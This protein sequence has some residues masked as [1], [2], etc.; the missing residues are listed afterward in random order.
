MS[1]LALVFGLV[2]A[3]AAPPLQAGAAT[4]NITPELGTL[5]V[6]G[7]VRDPYQPGNITMVDNFD[8]NGIDANRLLL[9]TAVL[10]KRVGMD[11]SDQ[12]IFVNVVGGMSIDEPAADLAVACAI[13]S[14][15]RNRPVWADLVFVGEVGLSGELR[16]TGQLARRLHEA[17]KLGFTRALATILDSNIT[18]FLAHAILFFVGTGPVKGFAVTTC[19]GLGTTIFTAFTLTRLMVAAWYRWFK[20]K[21]GPI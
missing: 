13:A 15:F 10:S 16:S 20:P 6:G 21:N 14:G 12:D 9:L 1:S 3:T 4:S 2:L 18:G 8:L 7:F 5:V 11:L 19:L 17:V